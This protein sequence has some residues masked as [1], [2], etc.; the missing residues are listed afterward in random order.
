[1][2]IYI[3]A[4]IY[5]FI[6]MINH[7]LTLYI[8]IYTFPLSFS[9]SCVYIY[10]VNIHTH[11][12]TSHTHTYILYRL[13]VAGFATW[14]LCSGEMV[15]L[16]WA[17][18]KVGKVSHCRSPGVGHNLSMFVRFFQGHV[19]IHKCSLSLHDLERHSFWHSL[20]RLHSLHSPVLTVI[21]APD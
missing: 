16:A 3:Y 4:H 9:Q 2:Y 15:T 17:Q 5:I 18:C 7:I 12:F 19:H 1:M 6:R 8:Y 10:S 14:L 11:T 21:S 13:A 20:A